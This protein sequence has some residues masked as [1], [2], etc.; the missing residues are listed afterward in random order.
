ML[1]IYKIIANLLYLIYLPVLILKGRNEPEIWK[2]RRGIDL[3]SVLDGKAQKD[4][5]ETNHPVRLWFHASSVGETKVLARLVASFK[6]KCPEMEYY[7]SNYTVTG[8]ALSK[9]L[10]PDALGR[11][12][13]PLDCYFPLKRLFAFFS[14][15]P[16]DGVVMVETE[17]WPY[18]IDSCRRHDLPIFL[19]NGRLSEKSTGRYRILKSSFGKLFAPYKKFLMQSD[20]D[21]QRMI[22]IGAE[23]Q[24]VQA[25]GNIKHDPENVDRAQMRLKM[26]QTLCLESDSFLFIAAS[27]RPGEEEMIC[28]AVAVAT[29]NCPT[30]KTI[31]APRHLERLGDVQEILKQ[32][33]LPYAM[34]SD[35]SATRL[36]SNII[37]MDR[38]GLL[39]DLFYG[40]DLAFVGG[41]LTNIGGHNIMEPVLCGVPVLYG[42]SIFN[43]TPAHKII[44]QGNYGRMVS[45]GD[46]LTMAID[47]CASG[48][49][50]FAIMMPDKGSSAD[51]VADIILGELQ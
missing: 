51:R 39:S 7:V 17:I 18:F 10:F 14:S 36:D 1:T 34:F 19:A 40:A 23:S 6:K 31:I 41:T 43:V 27:T 28:D 12:Y 4:G 42:S 30:M 13:F 26:R 5:T 47:R 38:I 3:F 33:N 29:K 2:Q 48:Q 11:F 21:R 32:K 45:T 15:V 37:L 9:Q 22:A 50:K 24:R 49:L 44:S 16:L 46:E 25:I 8:K 20:V 35:S